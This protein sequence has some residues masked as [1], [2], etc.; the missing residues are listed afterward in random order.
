MTHHAP[1]DT[2]TAGSSAPDETARAISLTSRLRRLWIRIASPARYE[3]LDGSLRVARIEIERRADPHATGGIALH[4]ADEYF[5]DERRD[6]GWKASALALLRQS[7]AALESGQIDQGWKLLHAA[8]RMELLGIVDAG[9]LATATAAMRAE[10]SKLKSWRKKAILAI[11]GADAS[12]PPG[13]PASL[14]HAALIRDEHYNNQ[15]YKDLLIGTQILFLAGVLALVMGG[16]MSLS[17]FGRLPFGEA[18]VPPTFHTLLAV[19]LFGNLGGTISAIVRAASSSTSVRIPEIASANRVSFIRILMGGASA[20]V[21]Y[22]ALRSQLTGMLPQQLSSAV[23]KLTPFTT[24][25]IAVAS[26]FT[27]RFVLRAVEFMLGKQEPGNTAAPAT[28]E[29]E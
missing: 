15:G 16:L 18:L 7:R 24:Y 22:L 28:N 9:E 19:M 14:A 8:R 3:R 4:T 20:V 27:E 26:G 12:A 6:R 25:V 10:A 2:M 29:E 13:S 11:I 5:G 21:I 17:Y 23:E 1:A